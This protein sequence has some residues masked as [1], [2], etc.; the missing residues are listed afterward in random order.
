MLARAFD[1]AGG[2]VRTLFSLDGS[3][4]R[5]SAPSGS[6]HSIV[7]PPRDRTSCTTN[8]SP[9]G[10]GHP[11]VAVSRTCLERN[12]FRRPIALRGGDARSQL[13]P[14]QPQLEAST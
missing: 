12:W 5:T 10:S 6:L 8:S 3:Q 13:D 1:H 4:Q 14:P 2:G 9:F 11:C 7:L